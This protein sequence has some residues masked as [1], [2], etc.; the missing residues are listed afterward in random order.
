MKTWVMDGFLNREARKVAK[1]NKSF[2]H[3]VLF[4][5]EFPTMEL[6]R[7]IGRVFIVVRP[8]GWI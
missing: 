7:Q 2:V 4:A 3:F 8:R 6:Y 5:V 1:K